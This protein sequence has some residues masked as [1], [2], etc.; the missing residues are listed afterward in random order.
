MI[1]IYFL[2]Q[3]T[4]ISHHHQSLTKESYFPNYSFVLIYIQALF[5]HYFMIQIEHRTLRAT[6]SLFCSKFSKSFSC[7][8][9]YLS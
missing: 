6:D 2:P 5:L 4:S 1:L 3:S 9:K 8:E 7:D